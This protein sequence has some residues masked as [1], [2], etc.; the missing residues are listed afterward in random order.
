MAKTLGGGLA[1]L[2][3]DELGEPVEEAIDS[4]TESL[5]SGGLE[6]AGET[7]VKTFD[8]VIKVVGELADVALPP[9]T[10]AVDFAGEHLELIAASATTAFA[11]FKGYK[12]V[13]EANDALSKG[14]SV[15]KTASAAVDAY[16]IR[17]NGLYGTG[18]Y[19][20]RYPYNRTGS[21]WS[22]DRQDFTCN[23]GTDSVECGDECKPDRLTGD[24]DRST[25]GW[26]WCI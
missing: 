17:S 5:E 16:N 7:V 20:K 18:S 3:P 25:G 15:W 8:N 13:T 26:A 24:G 4:I 21:C 6:D 12:V 2:L 22:S 14:A 1:D 19:F 11:A 10:K 9:L 23:G